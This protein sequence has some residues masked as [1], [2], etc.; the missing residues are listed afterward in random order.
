MTFTKDQIAIAR[1]YVVIRLQESS[2]RR[3]A[4]QEREAGRYGT[5]TMVER[6]AAD[7]G[8]RAAAFRQEHDFIN[9]M[10]VAA[11]HLGFTLSAFLD[12]LEEP[13]PI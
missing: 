1:Q 9:E 3:I 6:D 11:A 13:R 8:V 12:D 10:V 5:A 7:L 2:A 4:R